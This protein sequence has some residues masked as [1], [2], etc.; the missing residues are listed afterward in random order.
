M[1]NFERLLWSDTNEV[2]FPS[3]YEC[4]KFLQLYG[5]ITNQTRQA[6]FLD[7]RS[8]SVHYRHI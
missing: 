4:T 5:E 6:P 7:V 1:S 2:I 3:L 8:C